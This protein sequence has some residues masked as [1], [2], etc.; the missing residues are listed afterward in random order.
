[1]TFE[2][3]CQVWGSLCEVFLV[4]A[5]FG[6]MSPRLASHSPH[7]K[8]TPLPCSPHLLVLGVMGHVHRGLPAYDDNRRSVAS[9]PGSP[10]CA[11][12]SSNNVPA[13]GSDCKPLKFP[14]HS[15]ETDP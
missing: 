6:K 8:L 1:M 11:R 3:G 13:Q 9:D 10:Y 2:E 12:T 5:L 14:L 15:N 4:D 7:P